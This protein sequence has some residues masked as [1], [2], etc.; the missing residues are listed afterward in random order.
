MEARKDQ[1]KSELLSL[2]D[3]A[4]QTNPSGIVL[5]TVPEGADVSGLATAYK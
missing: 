5:P 1:L 4:A 3:S 2:A